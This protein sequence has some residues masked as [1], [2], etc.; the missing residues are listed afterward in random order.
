MLNFLPPLLAMLLAAGAVQAA[1]INVLY[2]D[3]GGDEIRL[4]RDLNGDGDAND[5]GETTRFF[6]AQNASGFGGT[7]RSA[8]A[9]SVFSLIQDADGAVYAGDGATDAV[10]AL[11]DQNGDGDAQ[12]AGEARI[13]F[14]EDNAAGFKLHTPNGLAKGADGAIYVVEADVLSD[15]SGDVVYR[16]VDLNGDGDAN[17]PG[18]ATKWLDLKALNPSSSPFGVSFDGGVAYITDTVGGDP[19]VVYRAEDANGDGVIGAGEVR[20]FIRDDNTFGVSV[21]F[22][23]DARG[24]SVFLWEFADFAGPMQLWRVTD[25]DDSGAIDAAAEATEIWSSADKGLKIGVGFAMSASA[26]G[27][28]LLTSAGATAN[29]RLIRLVDL[30]GDGDYNDPGETF[31]FL[32]RTVNGAYPANARPAIA[33][34]PTAIAPVPL[35]ATAGLL[36]FTLAGLAGLRRFFMVG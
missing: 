31:D 8:T 4:A 36:G 33:Y 25:L 20:E 11:R 15:Q 10:Y 22:A 12:D 30:N 21:G 14:S 7:G 2:G 17:D 34:A 6:N 9:A 13:W 1:S 3:M 32:S 24:G 29:D 5:P 18:E 27:S 26:D 16:T 23:M 28:I 19:D 35:P